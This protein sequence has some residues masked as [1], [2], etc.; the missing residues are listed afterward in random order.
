MSEYCQPSARFEMSGISPVGQGPLNL[1]APH[2]RPLPAQERGEGVRP[3]L[4]HRLYFNFTGT[5]SL[6]R[7]QLIYFDL[8]I[9]HT[10]RG[11]PA[12]FQEHGRCR[13]NF[14]LNWTMC[15]SRPEHC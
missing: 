3:N 4:R 9:E 8:Q 7:G 6:I 12:Q 5:R 2:P 13:R 14:S 10:Q 1:L 11:G 15:A